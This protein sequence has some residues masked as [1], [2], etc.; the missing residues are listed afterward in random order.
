MTI[1]DNLVN[2]AD[3]RETG[4]TRVKVYERATADLV[5]DGIVNE[6]LLESG[7]AVYK[8]LPIFT[9]VNHNWLRTSNKYT[10]ILENIVEDK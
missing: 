9:A 2:V 3:Y 1:E 5:Y 8:C 6:I 7:I 4:A 10:F